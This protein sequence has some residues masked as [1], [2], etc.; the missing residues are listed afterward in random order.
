MEERRA[1]T[2]GALWWARDHL[3]DH[4]Y[5]LNGDSW[6]DFNWL[7]LLTVDKRDAT[8]ATIALRRLDDASRYGV[9]E[10]EDSVVTSFLS[11]PDKS[12]PG[13]V[14]SGVYLLSRRILAYLTADCGL[15]HDVFPLLAKQG[16]VAG[17]IQTG[18]FIDIGVPDDFN[19]AQ[20]AIRAWRTRPAAFLDRG[21]N[22]QRRH[23][24]CP[25]G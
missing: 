9:V 19:L 6:F 18:K 8:L 1:G 25:S 24:L 2:G 22:D 11:R 13:N 20:I 15:E 10:I 4:F 3:D 12:G 21:R 5:L 23:R 16:L 14:N 7:S 17:S